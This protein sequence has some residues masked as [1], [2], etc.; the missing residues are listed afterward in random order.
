MRYMSPEQ[1]LGHTALVDHRTDIYS[2]GVTLYELAVLRHPFEDINDAALAFEHGRIGWRRPRYWNKSIPVDLENIILKAMSD[3]REERYATAR[4]LAEDL[5]RFLEGKP[6]LAR[7]PSLASRTSKWAWR[8]KR[9]VAAT[10]AVLMLAVSGLTASL[11]VISGE[12]TEKTLAYEIVKKEKQSAK[13]S[14]ADA[15][16][17][18]RQ[19][20]EMLDRFGSKVAER[21]ASVPGAEG[22]RKELLSEMLP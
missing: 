16:A 13:R 20:R 2:L 11:I 3:A 6:I 15:E 18:L 9:S 12:R 4:D 5:E 14:A 10:I 17:K 7:R 19:A 21:L 22:V 8:H 1:A